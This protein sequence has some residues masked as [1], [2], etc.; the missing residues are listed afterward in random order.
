MTDSVQELSV[1]DELLS[2]QGQSFPQRCLV[3]RHTSFVCSVYYASVVYNQIPHLDNPEWY[4]RGNLMSVKCVAISML[5]L[6]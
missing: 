1:I 2:I 3:F 4:V 6:A 5:F